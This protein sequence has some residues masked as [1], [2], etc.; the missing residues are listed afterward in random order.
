MIVIG[1]GAITAAVQRSAAPERTDDGDA[2]LPAPGERRPFSDLAANARRGRPFIQDGVDRLVGEPLPGAPR[3]HVYTRDG[4][5]LRVHVWDPSVSGLVEEPPLV[6]AYAGIP[7]GSPV[8]LAGAPDGRAIALI[9][10]PTRDADQQLRL[11]GPT[12]TSW[13]ATPA[14]LSR[15]VWSADSRHLVVADAAGSWLVVDT[16]TSPATVAAHLVEIDHRGD[17]PAGGAPD[18]TRAVRVLPTSF[19]IDGR[20]IYGRARWIDEPSRVTTVRMPVA[21][22][23]VEALDPEA[24][25]YGAPD[26]PRADIGPQLRDPTTGRAYDETVGAVVEVN[27]RVAFEVDVPGTV[28]SGG[29]AADG[30]LLL[31]TVG[32]TFRLFVIGPDG[33]PGDPVFRADVRSGVIVGER[34]G[35]V[36]VALPPARAA[37]DPVLAMVR[38]ADSAAAVIRLPPDIRER[39]AAFAWAAP[40][41]VP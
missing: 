5:D 13:E 7:E 6:G 9:V 2:A 15:A 12:G 35:F 31:A 8:T 4:D 19:S 32:R 27:G 28:V 38:L 3:V 33:R 14:P 24:V 40:D 26:G 37:G 39:I 41:A 16:T 18:A 21:G 1:G 17:D 25:P 30:R 29:W 20:W 11:V 36:L 22:G 34:D 23:A 10:H